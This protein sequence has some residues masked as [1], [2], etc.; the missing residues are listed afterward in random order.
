MG[1]EGED[2]GG[3]PP[4]RILLQVRHQLQDGADV[5]AGGEDAGAVGRQVQDGDGVRPPRRRQPAPQHHLRQVTD[6]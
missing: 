6:V 4:R 1:T 3:A 5:R 2:S